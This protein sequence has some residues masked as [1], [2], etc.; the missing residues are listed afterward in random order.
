[1][2]RKVFTKLNFHIP[3]DMV[4]KIVLSTA[5][6]IEPVLSTLREK[7]E[8]KLENITDNI[9]VRIIQTTHLKSLWS[10]YC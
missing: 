5:G 10:I 1:M 4:K 3:E 9:L 8:K 7:I 6:V 2:N